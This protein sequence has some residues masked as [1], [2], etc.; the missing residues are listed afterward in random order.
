MSS[1]SLTS[2]SRRATNR[3]TRRDSRR[4][5]SVPLA[6]A[7]RIAPAEWCIAVTLLAV[8]FAINVQL[9]DSA[10]LWRDEASTITAARRSI[11]QLF[12]LVQN[13][14]A[15]HGLYYLLMHHWIAAFG[16]SVFSLRVTAVL[17]F[18]VTVPV[19]YFL[20]RT[21]D[22]RPP[23][24]WMLSRLGLSSAFAMLTLPVW[25]RTAIEARSTALVTLVFALGFLA[26]LRAD[27]ATAAGESRARRFG[28]WALTTTLFVMTIAL[29]LFASLP[30]FGILLWASLTLRGA[31]RRA[32]I[33]SALSLTVLVL[34]FAIICS[35]QVGQISWISSSSEPLDQLVVFDQW[36]KQ[37]TVIGAIFY[38]LSGAL[39]VPLLSGRS[40]AW[41]RL[42]M[43][44]QHVLLLFMVTWIPTAVLLL[45][46][47]GGTP[48]YWPRYVIYSSVGVA[49]I[50]GTA[51]A[52]M[53]L[54]PHAL[55]SVAIIGALAVPSFFVGRAE[56]GMGG[57]GVAWRN[58]VTWFSS[59]AQA[60]DLVY[61]SSLDATQYISVINEN[62]FSSMQIVGQQESAASAGELL[63]PTSSLAQV[64]RST[65]IP[66]SGLWLFASSRADTAL[67]TSEVATTL[68]EKGLSTTTAFSSNYLVI[69][70]VTKK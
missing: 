14:D 17:A 58:G 69:V 65:S 70:H 68:A 35:T 60:R 42:S 67:D 4:V 20:G 19:M 11:P 63:A 7:R 13:I 8:T 26:F 22:R 25:T 56:K 66:N 3:A 16:A 30:V 29:N 47:L 46:G 15:V 10:P 6:V 39:L 24:R 31:R 44:R 27:G 45:I 50:M 33:L 40:V 38:L 32:A 18:S 37:S 55:L 9:I 53:R 28:W 2:V 61:F 49:L 34:P 1:Q 41:F 12:A 51:I 62:A 5:S 43:T 52:S 54:V 23:G 48:V 57:E 59:H 64:L 36:F 21:L